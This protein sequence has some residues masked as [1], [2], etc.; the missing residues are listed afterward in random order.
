MT[1]LLV[2]LAVTILAVGLIACGGSSQPAI[3]TLPPLATSAA[4]SVQQPAQSPGDSPL[5][6]AVEVPVQLR[7]NE[8]PAPPPWPT[9]TPGP[10][11]QSRHRL[12]YART[13]RFYTASADGSEMQTLKFA[14]QAPQLLASSYKDPGRGWLD[15]NGRYVVYFAGE[16]AQLWQASLASLENVQLAGRMLPLG[17][18]GDK[19]LLRILGE[20]EMDWTS[21]G[22]RVA[23]VGAPDTVDLFI[24]DLT[25][26]QLTRVTQDDLQESALHWSP[27]GQYLAYVAADQGTGTQVLYVVDAGVQQPRQVDTE[28]IQTTLGSDTAAG[29]TFGSQLTWVSD[30]QL[31]FYPRTGRRQR[32]AGIWSY[33]VTSGAVRPILTDA[34]TD[35][36]WSADAQ[37][38]VYSTSEAQGTLWLLRLGDPKPAVLVEGGAYAPVWSPEGRSVLYSWSEAGTTGWELRVVDLKG[39]SRTLARDVALIEPATLEPG[40]AGKRYWAPD[41]Q[42][43]LY[44]TVGRDYGR[45]EREQG[46][47]G[48]AGP[49]LENWWVVPAGG[50]E[51]RQA[52]DLQKA[53]YFQ[54]PVLSPDGTTWAFI[55][56]SY[57]DRVQHLYTMP[58]DGGHPEKVDAGVR[59][60]AWLP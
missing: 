6:L 29:F 59:W 17:K 47:G 9:F 36:A 30:T 56:F 20:Q 42:F 60:F 16:E 13:R 46:Y 58:R 34:V 10:E 24:V 33:D 41:A 4:S 45:A 3:P 44:T 26:A 53:F 57:T 28:P 25:T 40:P 2:L 43:V 7:G 49:D 50:G 55:G 15:P 54:E 31:V 14:T 37:A 51:P 8:E 5:N 35:V 32:S 52:T 23:L 27:T 12:I 1:R 39:S 48:E 22:R 21:D 18:E 11:P 19:D 38:W